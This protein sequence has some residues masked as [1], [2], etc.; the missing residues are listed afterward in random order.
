MYYFFE[1]KLRKR[2]LVREKAVILQPFSPPR[3]RD[4]GVGGA[5]SSLKV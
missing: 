2:L 4:S 1:K 3:K 5:E